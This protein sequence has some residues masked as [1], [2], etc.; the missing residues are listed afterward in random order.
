MCMCMY[1][2]MYM[3]MQIWM[4]MWMY[5]QMYI[6]NI[7]E[8]SRGGGDTLNATRP[9]SLS[10]ESRQE[11]L[12][13]GSFQWLTRNAIQAGKLFLNPQTPNPTPCKS[14][15]EELLRSCGKGLFAASARGEP[16]PGAVVVT[17][18]GS[19]TGSRNDLDK[20]WDC[21]GHMIVYSTLR[22]TIPNF[23]DRYGRLGVGGQVCTGVA[24]V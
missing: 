1:M 5:M 16:R 17:G 21:L 8:S 11:T 22:N 2:Y 12:K 10:W 14:V 15:R 4:W 24:Q 7:E 3:Q 13:H 6:N 9:G 19:G 20:V 23:S 18:W